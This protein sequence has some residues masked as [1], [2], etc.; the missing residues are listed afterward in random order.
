ML[1]EHRRA[2]G[3]PGQK[4]PKS[5]R[6]A[7][8]GFRLHPHGPMAALSETVV[9]RKTIF[10]LLQKNALSQKAQGG[11]NPWYHLNSGEIPHSRAQNAAPR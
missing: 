2:A 7:G 6:C 1:Q 9:F 11:Q 8:G 4:G 10:G 5:L 3:P